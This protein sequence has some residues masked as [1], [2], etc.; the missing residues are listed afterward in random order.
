MTW[1]QSYEKM[2]KNQFE[3][4]MFKLINDAVFGKTIEN[5]RKHR[6][7]KLVITAI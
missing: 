1:E 3:K 5:M 2:E 4:D 6:Y 7:I